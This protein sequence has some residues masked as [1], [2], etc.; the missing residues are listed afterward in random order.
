[1]LR[2]TDSCALPNRQVIALLSVLL[3]RSYQIKAL[4]EMCLPLDA[5]A[6][7]LGRPVVDVRPSGSEPD[8]PGQRA[9]SAADHRGVRQARCSRN[10]LIVLSEATEGGITGGATVRRG[11]KKNRRKQPGPARRFVA[12]MQMAATWSPGAH[13]HFRKRN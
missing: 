12:R 8:V 9:F 5:E 10:T 3:S 13:G 1:V 7:L 11:G 6:P 2:A 4:G